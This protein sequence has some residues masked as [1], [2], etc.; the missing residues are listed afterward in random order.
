MSADRAKILF[1]SSSWPLG[2]TFGGQL[3]AL[4]TARSLQQ[5]GDVTVLV[6]GSEANSA[7]GASLT[8]AEFKIAPPAPAAPQPNRGAWQR[9]RWALDPHYLNVHGFVV[10][11]EDRTRVLRSL[12][13]YDLIWVLNSRTPNLLQ[14]WRWPRSHLDIDDLPS[15]YLHAVANTE[16][17]AV[18]RWKARTQRMLLQRRERRFPLRFSTLSVCSEADRAHLRTR[19]GVHVIP[20]GF[21]RPTIAPQPQPAQPPR[22]GFIGLYSYA[23]N[24]EGVRWF[25]REV[26]PA[27]RQAVPGI[28]FRLVGRDTDGPLRPTEPDVDALGWL[29]DPAGEIASWSAMI[30]PIRIGGGTRIK[31]ADAFSRRCP[32][33]ST[34]FGAY[35]YAVEGGKQLLLADDAAAFAN[36]CVQLIRRPDL[37]REIAENAWQSFLRHWTWDAIA[38]KIAAAAQDCLQRSRSL[39]LV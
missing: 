25:L 14:T 10:S 19:D 32:V 2:R 9:L 37:G 23:P 35:G 3:R 38:P 29:A 5:V 13:D 21:P 36:A 20:N 8:R 28:R 17:A 30:I 33:V 1:I 22:L 6:V 15:S 31:I 26:W 39:S 27:V 24:H 11:P 12:G 7:E 4:H 16:R 34:R 18:K